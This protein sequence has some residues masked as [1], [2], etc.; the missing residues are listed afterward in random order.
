MVRLEPES[1]REV[2]IQVPNGSGS[3]AA[4]S[5]SGSPLSWASSLLFCMSDPASSSTCTGSTAAH[6]D[7]VVA[8]PSSVGP[9]AEPD[10]KAV[11]NLVTRFCEEIPALRAEPN[12]EEVRYLWSACCRIAPNGKTPAGLSTAGMKGMSVA[13]R[14][15][16]SDG[17]QGVWQQQLRALRI[18]A[19]CFGLGSC[20]RA[21]GLY[22]MAKAEALVRHLASDPGNEINEE[23]SRVLLIWQL[24]QVLPPGQEVQVAD[25]GGLLH[26]T[27]VPEGTATLAPPAS[28]NS[29][30]TT[31]AAPAPPAHFFSSKVKT[32]AGPSSD[33]ISM[34][35]LGLSPRAA[36]VSTTSFPSKVA[37]PAAATV[38]I[39]A[40]ASA[41]LQAT[42]DALSGIFGAQTDSASRSGVPAPPAMTQ[43]FRLAGD[44]VEAENEDLDKMYSF[45]SP[46]ACQQQAVS[47]SSA[48]SVAVASFP[49]V[50]EVWDLDLRLP[51]RSDPFGFIADHIHHQV[52]GGKILS[53]S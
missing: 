39:T 31:A 34:D 32:A 24:A 30:I 16:M 1:A 40:P 47:T 52:L 35:L 20:G 42:M 27:A 14:Q 44:E 36:A 2:V 8:G 5:Q 23:A 21:V 26:F 4:A 11:A 37:A 3:A 38:A 50:G 41:G 15:Q 29:S 43:H 53:C 17:C 6:E 45:S 18:L 49:A 25:N 33:L 51:P 48:A 46:K 10:N 22:T 12:S 13:L 7:C 28:S 19:F 9:K